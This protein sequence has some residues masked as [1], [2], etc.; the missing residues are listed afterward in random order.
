MKSSWKK[1][2]PKKFDR[3]EKLKRKKIAW[4]EKCGWQMDV[5]LEAIWLLPDV[6]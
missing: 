4:Q 3:M 2:G 1:T 6:H 5:E